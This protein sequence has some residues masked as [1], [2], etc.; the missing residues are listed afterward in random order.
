MEKL[1]LS[2]VSFGTNQE[3][4]D[5]LTTGFWSDFSS[6]ARKWNLS[7]SG[8]LA[9]NGEITYNTAGN[10]FDPDGISASRATLVEEAFTYL[11]TIT[12][13]D[14]VSTSAANADFNFGDEQSGAFAS[15]STIDEYIYYVDININS[16]WDSGL[17]ELGSYTF[18]TILHEIGHGLGLGHQG[19]YNGFSPSY[20]SPS[21]IF[22]N[23]S[24]QVSIMSYIDQTKNTS[25]EA[26][27][28]FLSSLMVSDL[29][30]LDDLYNSEGFGVSNAFIDDT[31]YGFNTNISSSTSSIFSGMKDLIPTTAY[32]IVDSSGNDTIDF[33][34]FN[35]KQL[36][37]LR[38][39]EK[40]SSNIYSSDIEGKKGNLIIAPGT[41]IENAI[42]GSANDTLTGNSSPNTLTGNEG[43]DTINGGGGDDILYGNDGADKLN[44]DNGDDSMYGGRGDDILVG[45]F[46]TDTAVYTGSFTDYS[47]S[48]NSITGAIQI[49]DSSSGRD[50]ADEVTKIESFT[51]NSTS[52]GVDYVLNKVG[53]NLYGYLASNVDLLAAFG[54]STFY[55]A[56]HFINH[57]YSE[58]RSTDSFDEWSYLAS[59][60]D[61]INAFGNDTSDATQ[62]YVN[63]GYSESRSTDSFDEWKYMAS[64]TDLIRA[65]GSD[66]SS[67]VQHYINHGY[68]EGRSFDN[69][70]ASSYLS[71]NGDLQA[72]FGSDLNA[73]EQHYVLHGFSEGRAI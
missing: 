73:A 25:T 48:L 19:N 69:F 44:G 45:G 23:D 3:L 24:W 56:E 64:N 59:H 30:A 43:S 67:A 37:D 60:T 40:T 47:F 31:V 68:A 52:Y 58:S 63:H 53:F 61:L 62:H 26:S 11:G 8:S 54:N 16:T 12:G 72:A 38:S 36:I 20:D 55:A 10:S 2:A 21:V 6:D 51:F 70:N 1:T 5:Y 27:Y 33:S 15:T 65:F 34:G 9:K 35:K 71:L 28:V 7:N 41:V 13:I 42:G 50:G 22:G 46:G 39:S 14:F 29:I 66:T 17:S 49:T 57:G 32:T 18:Q 4:A